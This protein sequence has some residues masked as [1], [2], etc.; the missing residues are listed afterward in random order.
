MQTLVQADTVEQVAIYLRCKR[1]YI[2]TLSIIDSSSSHPITKRSYIVYKPTCLLLLIKF[3]RNYDYIC[4]IIL[5]WSFK[6]TS[7]N[8]NMGSS[9]PVA[10]VLAYLLVQISPISC[11][12]VGSILLVLGQNTDTAI[13]G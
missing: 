12:V 10:E 6:Y 8:F 7:Q 3:N 2:T 5:Q 13:V 9:Q 1:A 11:N 4:T